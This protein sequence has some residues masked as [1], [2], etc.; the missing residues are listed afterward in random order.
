MLPALAPRLLVEDWPEDLPR[1]HELLERGTILI[2]TH[3]DN[4]EALVV[5]PLVLGLEVGNLRHARTTPGGPE[6][7]EHDL[8]RERLLIKGLTREER[9][10]DPHGVARQRQPAG[11][12]G[13][14]GCHAPHL[15]AVAGLEDRQERLV[16]SR[17]GGIAARQTAEFRR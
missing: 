11:R 1:L 4:L 17:R 15:L 12:A 13:S 16:G 5:P 10:G 3:A 6:V 14:P 7:D 2:E 8:A 9:A